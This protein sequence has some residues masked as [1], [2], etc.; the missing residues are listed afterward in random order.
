M[1]MPDTQ[2]VPVENTTVQLAAPLSSEQ[3]LTRRA[4]VLHIMHE[5]MKDGLHYGQIPG[6]P[7]QTLFQPGAEMLNSAFRLGWRHEV[8]EEV[9][10]PDVIRCTVR[11][12]IFDQ[13]SGT[14]LLDAVGSASTNEE[15]YKWRKSFPEEWN[16]TPV[17]LRREKWF[18]ASK[19]NNWTASKE[20]QVRT[21]PADLHNTI[22]AMASKRADVRTTRAALAVSDI[23]DVNSEDLPEEIREAIF[24]DDADTATRKADQQQKANTMEH[25]A[26]AGTSSQRAPKQTAAAAPTD[27]GD[28]KIPFGKNL[29]KALRD[30]PLSSVQWYADN[31]Q[32]DDVRA[33]AARYI[34]AV[35]QPAT[36]PPAAE[37][38]EP[39][40]DDNAAPP[41]IGDVN[42]D[43]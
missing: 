29:G 24:G 28:Y 39:Q 5:L 20:I 17:E 33:A 15:K 21:N 27:P 7:K 18:K 36:P 9:V 26:R 42:F 14:T 12:V 11:T 16:D 2:L 41:D 25:R 23:L 30:L 43:E 37:P 13:M 22:I 35:T 40:P 31:A 19:A 38:A 4:Q 8:L 34:A 10:T 3:L 32:Q 6:C 1:T